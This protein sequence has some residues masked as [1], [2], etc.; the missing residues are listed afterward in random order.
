M[1]V[2][3]S[4][5]RVVRRFGFLLSAGVLLAALPVLAD[6]TSRLVPIV[7]DVFSGTA[8]FTTELE[9]TN[10]E[11][12][13]VN[14]TLTYTASLGSGSGSV[15]VTLAA[16]RQ[17][18]IPD[19]LAYLRGKGLPI[20]S[21]S[22][23][24]QGGTLLVAFDNVSPLELV[25]ATARTTTATGAPQ[26]V[27]SAGLAYRGLT[28]TEQTYPG[29]PLIY[30]LRTNATDRSN[31]AVYNSSPSTPIDFKVTAFSGSGD[32][33]SKV[34]REALTVGP[35]GWAQLSFGESGFS[36]GWVEV[37]APCLG[38]A[39]CPGRA[40][41]VINNN[42]TNDGS[43]I[44]PVSGDFT[45]GGNVDVPAL[46]EAGAFRS[47]LILSN[48]AD[49]SQL[50]RLTYHESANA[51]GGSGIVTL[52]LGPAEQR[53]IP[54]AIQFLRDNGVPLAPAGSG[55]FV[56]SLYVECPDSDVRE[57]YAGARTASQST[58][59][60]GGQ[61]GLFSPEMV[62]NQACYTEDAYIFGLRADGTNRSNVAVFNFDDGDP[63]TDGPAVLYLQ[64]YD[65]DAGGAPAGAPEVVTVNPF[66]WKQVNNILALKGVR[67]GWVKVFS[68]D[69]LPGHSWAA[70]GVINDGGGPGQR[71]G[72]GAYIEMEKRAHQ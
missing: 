26:P 70:Y 62:I 68:P 5:R 22:A 67:N 12:N 6:S 10:A 43:Y 35:L 17:L 69:G 48:S 14:A 58:A 59:P 11:P 55:S 44:N 30:G 24:Q 51:A 71:T 4:C 54:N 25:S 29:I 13:A 8:H 7:L 38:E 47:E 32:G 63:T 9:L 3:S 27:G 57:M 66:E 42:I 41:G 21:G 34:L 37:D 46:V 31:V 60:Q 20:P 52:T 49:H 1:Q 16:G 23:G 2:P 50:F 18:D 53:I 40:Y 15:P 36:T 39:G 33:Q 45:V 28:P 64:V 19:A 65:G 61:Y 72:D 56:G